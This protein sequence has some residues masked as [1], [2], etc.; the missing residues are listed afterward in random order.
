MASATMFSRK[1]NIKGLS[2]LS[3]HL[4]C[5]LK[6]LQ[7]YLQ[8]CPISSLTTNYILSSQKGYDT[9]GESFYKI[10]SLTEIVSWRFPPRFFHTR[11]CICCKSLNLIN[12]F[13]FPV[14]TAFSKWCRFAMDH[15]LS[16]E[17]YGMIS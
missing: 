13:S 4:A 14:F 1:F 15:N 12:Q 7:K 8:M 6:D 17:T 16:W 9:I 5:F 3:F 2:C 11:H 10:D